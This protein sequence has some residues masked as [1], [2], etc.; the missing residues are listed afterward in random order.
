MTDLMNAKNFRIAL[1]NNNQRSEF[2]QTWVEK[3]PE[4]LRKE[5]EI[6]N[7][8]LDKVYNPWKTNL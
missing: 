7:T 4:Q 6:Y 3:S 2:H 8:E 1:F 5:W